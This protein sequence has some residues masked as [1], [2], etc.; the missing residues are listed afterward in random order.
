MEALY[1]GK[2]ANFCVKILHY[3]SDFKEA[4]VLIAET[5]AWQS[6]GGFF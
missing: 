5:T 2:L 1:D 6:S 4:V 3:L